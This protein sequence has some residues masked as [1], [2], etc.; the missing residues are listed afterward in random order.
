MAG[1]LLVLSNP[2]R[3]K[4]KKHA[5]KAKRKS[6]FRFKARRNP[7]A[8]IGGVVPTLK[9]AAVGTAGA[10]ANDVAFGFV[11]PRLPAALQSDLAVGGLKILSALAIGYIANKVKPGSGRNLAIG[12]AT[13]ALHDAARNVIIA[14]APAA[15]G[16]YIGMGSIGEYLFAPN[17]VG[18]YI[19]DYASTAVPVGDT[20]TIGV[21]DSG[22]DNQ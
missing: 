8:L 18:E 3:R 15:L 2:S 13:C 21:G 17:S 16:E 9:L 20:D 11:R 12:A 22:Y 10:L 1:S 14:K 6:A 7:S 19:G 4:H 5:K